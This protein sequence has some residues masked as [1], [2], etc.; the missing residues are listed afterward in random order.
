MGEDLDAAEVE[1]LAS[2]STV[3][4]V[5]CCA[6]LHIA[7]SPVLL[8]G[9]MC[10]NPS[11]SETANGGDAPSNGWGSSKSGGDGDSEVGAVE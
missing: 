7:H 6:V 9:W 8:R 1:A 2:V 11:G 5:H 10:L 3:L 4:S